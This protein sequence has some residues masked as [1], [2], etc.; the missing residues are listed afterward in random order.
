VKP[1]P[2]RY[3]RVGSLEH[4]AAR[5]AEL[6]EDAKI[7][8][9]GQ[10]LVAMMSLRLA[11]PNWLLDINRVPGLSY[12]REDD[13]GLHIGALT[14]H[15]QIERY[16]LDLGRFAVLQQTAGLVGHYPIRSRGTFAGSLAHADPV[17]E[18]CV[19]ALLLDAEVLALSTKGTRRIPARDYF[20]GFLTTALRPDEVIIEVCLPPPPHRAALIEYAR[21]HGD[22]AIVAAAVACET[23]DG[24]LRDVR[25]A[26]GG[27]ADR[28][29]RLPDVEQAAEGQPATAG[30]FEE[31]GRAAA[32]AVDPP[33]DLHATSDYRRLLTARLVARAFGAA[34]NETQGGE[35]L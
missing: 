4:A 7:L 32:A 11:R 16:P 28:P 18:W 31:I 14:R 12:L 21:R 13:R 2:F 10:S 33:A 29:L 20:E 35:A 27:V 3:E 15:G 19:L 34:L 8:A 26:L 30:M 1:P 9:G 24:C 6:G 23:V 22:F 5:L 17:A 25:V